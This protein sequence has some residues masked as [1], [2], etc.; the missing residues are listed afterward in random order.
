MK[1]N[2]ERLAFVLSG[3]HEVSIWQ[4]QNTA[5]DFYSAKGI[6]ERILFE[7]GF[8]SSRIKFESNEGSEFFHPLRSQLLQLIKR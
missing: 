1:E 5:Y 4:K 8:A 7:L 3:N 2:Q 6:V